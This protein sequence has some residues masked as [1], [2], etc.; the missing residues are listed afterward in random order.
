MDILSIADSLDAATDYIGRP[1]GTGKTLDDLI[2]EF[3][4]MGGTRYSLEVAEL[5]K[6]PEIHDAVSK[7]ITDRRGEVNYKIYAFNEIET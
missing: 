7:I 6:K 2:A 1:Y 3:I 5:L 4:D